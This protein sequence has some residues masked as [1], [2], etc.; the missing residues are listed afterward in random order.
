MCDAAIEVHVGNGQNVSFWSDSWLPG[1]SL[2]SLALTLFGEISHRA[3]E[4]SVAEA[5][6]EQGWLRVISPELSLEVPTDLLVV[7]ERVAGRALMTVEDTFR[8]RWCTSGSYT[9]SSAYTAFFHGCESMAAASEIW[10]SRAPGKCQ[11][12]MWLAVRGRCWTAD[13]LARHGMPH[14][15]RCPLSDQGTETIDHLLLGCVFAR[16]VWNVVLS[17]WERLDWLP[18]VDASLADWWTS[19]VVQNKKE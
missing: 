3:A 16:Q 12:F 11:F 17:D 2:A 5:L 18:L 7:S 8:W 6:V 14:P 4:I 19:L 10:S 1:G 13:R 9:T 15:A